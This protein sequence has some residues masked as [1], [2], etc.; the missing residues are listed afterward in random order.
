MECFVGENKT[1]DIP[2]TN[3]VDYL[4]KVRYTAIVASVNFFVIILQLQDKPLAA[5]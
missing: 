5:I 3:E 1:G 4:L 2:V